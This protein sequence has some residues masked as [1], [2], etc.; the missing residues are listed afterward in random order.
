M[1]KKDDIA[2]SKTKLKAHWTFDEVDYCRGLAANYVCSNCRH[3]IISRWIKD[4][5]YCFNCGAKM[6]SY[7]YNA[8]Q[9]I[10]ENR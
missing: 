6:D 5:K 4:Y 1:I 3:T 2:T 7:I 10:Q 8:P 9:E